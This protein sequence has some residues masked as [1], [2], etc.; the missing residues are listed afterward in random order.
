M[1]E[2]LLTRRSMA[3]LSAP[4]TAATAGTS[5]GA[6]LWLT[7]DLGLARGRVHEFC[8][9]ARRSLAL[10]AA[11]AEGGRAEGGRAEGTGATN[12]GKTGS[13]PA[14]RFDRVL[15]IRPRW[16]PD[17]LNPDGMAALVDPRCVLSVHVQRAEDL[18]W[19]MEEA[20]RSGA[21]SLVIGDLPG[22]PGLTPVR[23]LHL[24]AEAGAQA[25]AQ[26]GLGPA[27]LGLLLTPERGGAP[28]VE[29]RWHLQP[30][31]APASVPA[32]PASSGPAPDRWV[33]ERCR[34]RRDPPRA[35]TL[36]R[37]GA[38]PG[39]ALRLSDPPAATP[40]PQADPRKA[41]ACARPMR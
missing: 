24:A 29:S 41:V 6:R 10:M 7:P 11:S 1:S 4:A 35:W 34:D 17:M 37:D 32:P 15:W 20:L 8:G 13:S 5:P 40:A 18:L 21:V 30:A 27:P 31:S 19:C 23:R 12:S 38:H 22:P 26:A 33:L 16:V 3:K 28:G 36:Q 25:N 9:S 39:A 2:T 14:A